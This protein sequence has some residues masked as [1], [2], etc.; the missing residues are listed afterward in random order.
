MRIVVLVPR[1]G[2]GFTLVDWGHGSGGDAY[3]PIARTD[4]ADDLAGI[5]RRLAE[6]GAIVV[7]GDHPLF[8]RRFPFMELGFDNNLLVVNIP[9][10]PAFRA[11]FQQ[12]AVDQYVRRRF[13]REVLPGLLGPGMV[14]ASRGTGAFGHS[15]GAQMAGISAGFHDD[16]DPAAPDAQFLNGTGGQLTHSV[17]ASDLLQIQGGVGEAIFSLAGLTPDPDA[18]PSEVLGALLGV[19]EAAWPNVDRLHPLAL[20]FQ[21]VV[22]GADPLAIAREHGIA[23]DVMGGENDSKVPAESFAWL[24][25]ASRRGRLAPCTPS[26]PYDGHVCVFREPAGLAGFSRLLGAE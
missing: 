6:L 19:P 7:S 11:N 14:D 22:D 8:G 26:T 10:L 5:R 18:T 23:I 13:A 12:G 15:I 2:S 1:S 17:I 9:N 20:P 3:E 25:E 24:A 4:E 16:D 21:L